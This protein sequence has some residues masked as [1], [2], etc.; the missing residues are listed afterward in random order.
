MKTK[1]DLNQL[2]Q[3]IITMINTTNKKNIIKSM[4]EREHDSIKFEGY[5]QSLN[6]DYETEYPFSILK[7]NN[8]I[9]NKI[10]TEYLHLIPKTI[11]DGPVVSYNDLINLLSNLKC[12]E[13]ITDLKNILKYLKSESFIA[14]QPE[15]SENCQFIK[16]KFQK[17]EFTVKLDIKAIFYNTD[18]WDY[19]IGNLSTFFSLNNSQ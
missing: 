1:D 3:S 12:K 7:I 10:T 16:L 9:E 2:M 6:Y 11:Y 19:P 4:F 8:K 17:D 18:G 15:V 14:H 13:K 5:E